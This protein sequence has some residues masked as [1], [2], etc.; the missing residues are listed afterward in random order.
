MSTPKGMKCVPRTLVTGDK[1]LIYSDANHIVLQLRHLVP[2]EEQLLEPSF[3][4]GVQLSPAEAIALASDLL[5]AALPQLAALR[6]TVEGETGLDLK[7][8]GI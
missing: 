5:N 7:E 2:T 1:V 3:K 8:E 4:V 6:A